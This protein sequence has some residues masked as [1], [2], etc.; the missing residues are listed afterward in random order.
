[1]AVRNRV[2]ALASV[3]VALVFQLL[4]R[5]P[6]QEPDNAAKRGKTPES[7]NNEEYYVLHGE[8]VPKLELSA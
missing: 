6:Y 8:T 1:M 5:F 2:K 7:S 4:S 3:D